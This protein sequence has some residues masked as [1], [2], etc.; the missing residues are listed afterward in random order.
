ML[1]SIV[2]RSIA[3]DQ[4][5][6]FTLWSRLVVSKPI[7]QRW[8]ASA[9]MLYR[10]QNDYHGSRGNLLARPLLRAG[11]VLVSYRR[12]NWTFTANPNFFY[13]YQLLGKEDDYEVPPG[14][15]WR[16]AGFVENAHPLKKWT[17]RNRFGYEYR[18]LERNDWQATG[19]L[20]YRLQGRYAFR[21][22]LT[23]ILSHELLFNVGPNQSGPFYNQNQLLTSLNWRMSERVGV[24]AGY[25]YLYRKRR[26]GIEYDHEHAI[27]LALTLFL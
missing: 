26:N 8:S 16:L 19:R 17:L 9:E 24:E 5:R 15:E 20:R 12:G 10:Q 6:H 18:M 27:N 7:N 11:R 22:T 25:L 23:G 21:P 14:G 4:Y 13:S 3:Q 2:N 1:S